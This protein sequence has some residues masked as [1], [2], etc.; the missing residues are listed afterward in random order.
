MKVLHAKIGQPA[1]E[2]PSPARRTSG[3][4]TAS[5]HVD[6][7]HG[8]RGAVQE[9]QH[10]QQAFPAS[11]L[12]VPVA[13]LE[14]RPRQP[15]LG[16][17][18]HVHPDGARLRLPGRC[19]GLAQPSRAGPSRVDHHGADFC[20]AALEEAIARHG[21]AISMDGRGGWRDNVFVDRLWK[22]IKYE[23]VYL[24][25]YETVSTVRSGLAASFLHRL[26]QHPP[27]AQRP[28]RPHPRGGLLRYPADIRA[29][30][31][32]RPN[33]GYSLRLAFVASDA[34]AGD[35]P[36]PRHM[37]PQ[38]IHLSHRCRVFKGTELPL[39]TSLGCAP[40]P[41]CVRRSRDEGE[42]RGNRHPDR[43]SGPDSGRN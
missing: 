41:H 25:A 1:A 26:L 17:G 34:V 35:N 8:H 22:S 10:Q 39:T 6:G 11:D 14:D 32:S 37:N 12:P 38:L 40:W 36:A 18:H 28:R 9:A 27:S 23:D 13:R 24:K 16:D 4:P 42:N 30:S 20:I 21:I 43:P 2:W 7:A 5:R 31:L 29:G 3:R 15:G 33:T 19:P